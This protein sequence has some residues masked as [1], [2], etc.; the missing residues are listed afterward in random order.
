MK[1]R[2]PRSALA[3][4]LRAASTLL[5]APT[6]LAAT[7]LAALALAGCGIAPQSDAQ[8]IEPPRGP[9]QAVISPSPLP[10]S[11]G[12]FTETL[13]LVKDELIVPQVRHVAADASV[14]ELI[15]DLLAGPTEA[16]SAAGL[17]SAL[18]GVEV[19][20]V[21]VDRGFAT[22]DLA[23]P[24]EGGGRNDNLLAYAQVV[25]TLTARR[26]VLAVT[27]TRAGRPID[28]PRG[29]SSVLPGPLTA[30]DYADLIAQ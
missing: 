3:P 5:A 18:V 15:S 26:D 13:Y 19:T 16:E 7:V 30:S 24:I 1:R 8:P 23:A 14:D 28:V 2:T 29:D 11:S 17:S 10:T 27:F 25:C 6:L 21:R 4:A 20:G 12:S 22:V 9:F